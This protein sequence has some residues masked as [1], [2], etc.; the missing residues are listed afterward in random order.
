VSKKQKKGMEPT[1][2][3]HISP[4]L[5]RLATPVADLW[6]DPH[7]ARKH[8]DRNLE[9]IAASLRRFGQQA[10]VVYVV[11]TAGGGRATRKK[12][13]VIKGSGL[14]QAASRILHWRTVA[15]VESG[16]E[17]EAATAFAIADNRSSDLS[18]FDEQLL[19]EQLK[20]LGE[21]DFSLDDVGFSEGEFA[22]LMKDVEDGR[23]PGPKRRTAKRHR[24]QKIAAFTAGTYTFDVP[25]AE[26][27]RWVQDLAEK[28]TDDPD[29]IIREIR[30]RLKV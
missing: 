30:R 15:A 10:P 7:N 5:R 25:R 22:E 19:A 3:E 28:V 11:S 4:S 12:K 26:Y 24:S 1:D 9:A 6:P 23:A 27:E 18:E 13:I 21:A 16:L 14:L 2:V 17:G 8:D 29:A 20:E